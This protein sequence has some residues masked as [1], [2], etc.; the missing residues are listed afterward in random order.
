MRAGTAGLAVWLF[1]TGLAHA[2]P[3]DTASLKSGPPAPIPIEVFAG[4]RGI[5]FL[6]I[7]S[8]Q[9]SPGS[10]FGL[11]SVTDFLGDYSTVNQQNEFASINFLTA[12]VWKGFSLNSGTVLSSGGG[13]TP[14]A[15]VQY[16]FANQKFL[17]VVLPRF[18]LT[19]TYNFSTLALVE[20]KPRFNRTWGLY[21]RVQALYSQD[22][23]NDHHAR[24]FGWYR[25]GVS[26]RNVQFGIGGNLDFYGPERTFKNAL[27]FFVRTELH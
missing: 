10:R 9:F 27:G 21:T 20:Y 19:K 2:T 23:K 7:V 8:K 17:V 12:R 13:F 16:L 26:Y 15:G 18:D 3:S 5:V 6:A 22:T 11:I 1:V 4:S 14:S 25:V 24:S